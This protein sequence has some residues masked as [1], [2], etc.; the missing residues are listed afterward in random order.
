MARSRSPTSNALA[1]RKRGVHVAFAAPSIENID[2]EAR[3]VVAIDR[4]TW[5]IDAARWRLLVRIAELAPQV[6]QGLSAVDPNDDAEIRAW[7]SRWQLDADWIRIA[8]R[9][10]LSLWKAWPAAR[11]LIWD[12][13]LHESGALVSARGLPPRRPTSRPGSTH[14]SKHKGQTYDRCHLCSQVH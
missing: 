6:L 4:L 1:R 5:P 2:A 8:A 11:G 7:A 12:A 14:I 3:R 9:N 10:T 13:N